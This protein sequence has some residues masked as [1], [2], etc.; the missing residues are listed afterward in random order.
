MLSISYSYQLQ[1][2]GSWLLLMLCQLAVP[3]L[4]PWGFLQYCLGGAESLQWL[5]DPV[6]IFQNLILLLFSIGIMWGHCS[7]SSLHMLHITSYS[8]NDTTPGETISAFKHYFFLLKTCVWCISS[9]FWFKQEKKQPFKAIFIHFHGLQSSAHEGE[10]RFARY[11]LCGNSL[12]ALS[13]HDPT[14]A[15][16][17]RPE[18]GCCSQ[19]KGAGGFF[20]A[21]WISQPFLGAHLVTAHGSKHE[22]VMEQEE[23]EIQEMGRKSGAGR[24]Q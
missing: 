8:L 23:R 15:T 17:D 2:G 1:R 19:G 6:R 9:L 12:F 10:A 14:A 13:C 5:S 4:P 16:T 18:A 3:A 22:A 20:S 7:S 24:Y 21:I 11:F